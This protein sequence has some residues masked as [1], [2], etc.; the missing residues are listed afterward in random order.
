MMIAPG[1]VLPEAAIAD[2]CRRHQ[3]RELSIFGSAVRGELRPDSDI[4]L[5]V[6]YFPSA[7]PSLFDLIGMTDEL[8]NLLGRKVDLGVKRALKPRFKDHILAEAHVIYAA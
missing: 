3:V 7:R 1:I 4:D 5:L 2:I 8:S 6:D